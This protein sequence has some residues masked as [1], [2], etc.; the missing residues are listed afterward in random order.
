MARRRKPVNLLGATAVHP[1]RDPAH[2]LVV[3]GDHRFCAGDNINVRRMAG[4]HMHSQ[5]ELNFVLEGEMTYWFDGREL[6]V[7]EGRLCLFWGMIPHQVTDIKEPTRFICLYV[8]MS[9]F[10]A[11]PSLSR[12]RDAVFRGAMIEALDIRP[13]DRDIFMRWREELLSG[14]EE[15]EQIV[16]EELGARVRRLDREGWR[17]L[18]EQG[19]AIASLAHHDAD[20]MFHVERMMRFITEHALENITAEDVGRDVGLHPNYAMGIFKRTVGMT[21]NQS[22]VRHR[23]DTAQSLLISTDLPITTVAFEAGFGSL[24]RFY[25]AFHDRFGTKPGTFRRRL[26]KPPRAREVHATAGGQIVASD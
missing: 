25:E 19:S 3:F 8:P 22:I 5:I 16:R 9:V 23:L 7:S 11:L 20:R 17:D 12:F 18:R 21:I 6:S 10:L 26:A 13:Y 4:P 15:L 14:D 24:S 2:P 1:E